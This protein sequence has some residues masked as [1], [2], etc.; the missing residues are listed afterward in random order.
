MTDV[1]LKMY[2]DLEGAHTKH[3]GCYS[4]SSLEY[5]SADAAAP[6]ALDFDTSGSH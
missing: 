6:A 4:E 2:V 5:N 1:E 3:N